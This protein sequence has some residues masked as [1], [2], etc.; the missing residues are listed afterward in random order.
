MKKTGLLVT[1]LLI[2]NLSY[3]QEAE[4]VFRI[5]FYNVENLFDLDDHP[6]KIDEE[7]TPESDKSWDEEKYTKKLK[8]ITSVIQA[9]DKRDL[10]EII[11]LCE[12]E[13]QKVLRDLIEMRGLRSGNYDIIHYESPDIRG[14][15][16][17]LLYRI[18]EFTVL[19]SRPIPVTFPFD[20]TETTRNILYVEGRTRDG[21]K[22]HVFVNHW[23]SRSAGERETRTERRRMLMDAADS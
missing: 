9:V 19:S 7:F 5:M 8:D 22:L 20:S 15:D 2:L 6:D 10:P 1:G 14:I 12:V 18:E 4:E 17:A 21:E 16:C 23:S 11:G 13:N 3:S